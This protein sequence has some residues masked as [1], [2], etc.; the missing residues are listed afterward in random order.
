[1]TGK[2]EDLVAFIQQH[3]LWQFA[4]RTHDREENIHGVL[5]LLGEILTGNS[6][7]LETPLE[8]CHFA[9]ANHLAAEAKSEFGWLKDLHGDELN[10]LVAATIARIH[11]I[12]VEHSRNEELKLQNY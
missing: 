2:V 6:P 8:R 5:S 3:C 11:E 10:Q 1:M 9:N 4:S 7:K 12:T